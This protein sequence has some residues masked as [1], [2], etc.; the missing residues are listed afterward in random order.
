MKEFSKF[1]KHNSVSQNVL[2][3]PL[4]LP[5]VELFK[6]AMKIDNLLDKN[7]LKDFFHAA[8]TNLFFYNPN[9]LN[10][11]VEIVDEVIDIV[12]NNNK[13]DVNCIHFFKEENLY[14]LV[15]QKLRYFSKNDINIRQKE[16]LKKEVT[17]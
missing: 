8:T 17:T 11:F 3:L 13:T 10:K 12:A 6:K 4:Y 14:L 9:D 2:K 7:C 5:K 15:S 1:F 16:D